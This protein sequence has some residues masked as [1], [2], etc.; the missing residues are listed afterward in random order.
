VQDSDILLADLDADG[1]LRLTLNDIRR[2]NALSEA[3]LMH[4]ARPL[5]MQR[6]T[7]RCGWW[8]WP[9]RVRPSARV[10]I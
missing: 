8:C 2:R 10:M 6:P 4:W 7:L 9:R 3:M 5:Q 1:I